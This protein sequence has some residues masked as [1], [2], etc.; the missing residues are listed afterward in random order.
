MICAWRAYNLPCTLLYHAFRRICV[1]CG[2]HASLHLSLTYFTAVSMRFLSVLE[3][4]FCCRH[5]SSV[6]LRLLFLLLVP[7]VCPCGSIWKDPQYHWIVALQM[8]AF[9]MASH[10]DLF[11]VAVLGV[12]LFLL[13]LSA[14]HSISISCYLSGSVI[15]TVFL[16]LLRCSASYRADGSFFCSSLFILFCFKVMS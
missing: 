5:T 4:V 16:I 9:P 10:G 2:L 8:V 13:P 11:S 12:D 7:S 1:V 15:P 14:F 6:L 3:R